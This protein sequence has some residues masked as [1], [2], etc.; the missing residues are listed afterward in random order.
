MKVSVK[1]LIRR[2]IKDNPR[3]AKELARC[4]D[5]GDQIP[6]NILNNLVENRL[7]QSDCKVNG[8]ILEGFPETDGQI[9]LLKSM[10]LK[11][12]VVFFFDLED[13]DC[14]Q[15][16]SSRR[17]DPVTGIM[18]NLEIDP[19]SDEHIAN[20]MIELKEDKYDC[21]KNKLKFWNAN[22]GKLEEAYKS[23]I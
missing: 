1:E 14:K 5:E 20:R 3:N 19:P 23:V 6:E 15:R 11:P 2:E 12:S 4:I 22:K 9:N 7:N 8:W 21:V 17:L 16:L 13:A 10:R 18:Y